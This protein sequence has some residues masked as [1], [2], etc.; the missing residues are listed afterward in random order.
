MN[1]FFN[2]ILIFIVVIDNNIDFKTLFLIT[3][4]VSIFVLYTK[5][6]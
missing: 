5:Y 1:K 2:P 4:V 3:P 6:E